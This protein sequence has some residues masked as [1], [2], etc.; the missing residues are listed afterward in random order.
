MKL[1]P[2]STSRTTR[3]LRAN[4][5]KW[6]RP[7]AS[8]SSRRV[9]SA[10]GRAHYAALSNA[11]PL[12]LEI[13]RTEA[14]KSGRFDYDRPVDGIRVLDRY[15]FEVR[16][17]EPDPRFIFNFAFANYFAAVAR[18]VVESVSETEIQARP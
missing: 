10:L 1:R 3:R 7:T 13:L 17:A 11:K 5:A 14:Q 2:A 9:R 6:W 16:L 15:V 12:G 4:A 8:T 18:E